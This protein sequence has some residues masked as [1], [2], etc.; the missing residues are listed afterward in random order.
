MGSAQFSQQD[1]KNQ[2]TNEN[3]PNTNKN[4][5][6]LQLDISDKISPKKV[7]TK[8][9]FLDEKN[10][11]FDCFKKTMMISKTRLKKYFPANVVELLPGAFF[12][13]DIIN[14][15]QQ[16]FFFEN[17]KKFAETHGGK[18][19]YISG[20]AGPQVVAISPH[21]KT[22]NRLEKKYPK[23][24][25]QL[26]NIYTES[27]ILDVLPWQV[28]V[29]LYQPGDKMVPHK[30]GAGTMAI[31]TTL[32]SALILDFYLKPAEY[33]ITS[34]QTFR[35]Q[36]PG[37]TVELKTLEVYPDPAVQ[38]LME[39]GSALVLTGEAFLDYAHGIEAGKEDIITEKVANL[40]FLKDKYTLGDQIQ[41]KE[42]VS[43]V[44]WDYERKVE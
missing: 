18:Q 5:P 14:E 40:S 22:P 42:R 4:E 33:N 34:T 31:I 19:G 16:T 24:V 13:P 23:F 15:T 2:H 20:P 37:S 43:V 35:K 30:D 3:P 1:N 41:R 10:D 21:T 11:D 9:P 32:G 29:N 17:C 25:Q 44:M 39:P 27:Q 28:S 7:E 6:Q 38:I 36:K 12:F 8:D 26:I